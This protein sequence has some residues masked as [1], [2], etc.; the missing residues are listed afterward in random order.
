[1][2]GS[3]Q[4]TFLSATVLVMVIAVLSFLGLIVYPAIF[5][6][7]AY[8]RG[9]RGGWRPKWWNYTLGGIGVPI[10]VFFGGAVFLSTSEGLMFAFLLHSISAPAAS[11]HYLYKRHKFVGV[12]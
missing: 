7:S 11:V 4:A 3:P 2:S 12:P 10:V 1:M 8:L 6:D 5:R 9:T